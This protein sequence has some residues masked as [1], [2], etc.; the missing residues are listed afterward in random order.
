MVP[1]VELRGA[2]IYAAVEEMPQ[3]APILRHFEELDLVTHAQPY[4]TQAHFEQAAL[5]FA[6]CAPAVYVGVAALIAGNRNLTK[7]TRIFALVL[8][9]LLVCPGVTNGAWIAAGVMS[10]YAIVEEKR[11][12]LPACLT[13]FAVTGAAMYPMLEETL[14]PMIC[15]F[16]LCLCALLMALDVLPTTLNLTESEE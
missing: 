15:A 9:A 13:L 16:A 2:M 7:T 8:C 11:L 6:L 3:Y 4:Y 12:R 10:L 1:L 5:G 14:L